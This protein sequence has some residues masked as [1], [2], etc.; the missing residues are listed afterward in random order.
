M[1]TRNR[2]ILIILIVIL[3]MSAVFVSIAM[4]EYKMNYRDRIEQHEEA[5][6]Y[7]VDSEFEKLTRTY[8][9]RLN[10]FTKANKRIVK[11]FKERDREALLKLVNPRFTTFKKE[12]P[13]FHNVNFILPDGRLLLS[14]N[15][16]D[17]FRN[18]MSVY[19][20]IQSI[21]KDT[22]ALHGYII[23][24]DR[25]FFQAVQTVRHNDKNIGFV[26]FRVRTSI[27]NQIIQDVL[28]AEYALG[29]PSNIP[30]RHDDHTHFHPIVI[31]SSCS[32]FDNLPI[33]F[34][35]ESHIQKVNVN[36]TEYI[37]HN[38]EVK[39]FKGDLIGH[40]FTSNDI[41]KLNKRFQ[42]FFMYVL[43]I[44][45]IVIIL[46]ASVLYLGFGAI[47]NK[48]EQMNID[49]ETTI[50][51]RTKELKEANENALDQNKI[52]N[53]LY[54]RFKSMF[55]DHHSV[56]FLVEPRQGRVVDANKAA[57]EFL[58]LDKKQVQKMKISDI[59]LMTEEQVENIL[60]R[61]ISE[62]LKNYISKF[63]IF[64]VTYDIEIQASPIEIDGRKLLFAICYDVTEKVE[65][66]NK[67]KEMNKNLENMATEEAEKRQKQEHLLIQQ[68]KMSSVGEVLSAIIHQWKQPM[69]A[70]S[71]LMQD[72]S[73]S[74]SRGSTDKA[75]LQNISEEA[76]NQI[77]YM[78]QTVEDF[79]RFLM[80]SKSKENFNITNEVVSVIG[81]LYKQ[82]EKDNISVSVTIVNEEKDVVNY[83]AG[84]LLNLE[85]LDI[86]TS[87]FLSHG[88]PS[89]FKQVL[90]NV[91]HNSRDAINEKDESS[92]SG[93]INVV[94]SCIDDYIEIS[95]ADNAGGIPPEI[96]DKVFEPYF[97]TKETSGTGIGLYM[98]KSIIES[99]MD[100][101]ITA[102]NSD[103]GA[104]FTIKLKKSR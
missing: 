74:C 86:D 77:N 22:D 48:V 62:G 19:K 85:N 88:Y 54:K 18:D 57:L 61:S 36:N 41:T 32:I 29:V 58:N 20:Y 79:R 27:M 51:N 92:I 15:E 100:G 33:S 21:K 34:D 104:L 9:S 75:Y 31:D 68:S 76:L 63:K 1:D 82:I 93:K 44:T 42:A 97:T 64:D 90:M 47:L 8:V 23:S 96:L 81:I 10:G 103:L 101:E 80:P 28:D 69:T 50:A 35:Y 11:A 91:I 55:Q 46:S 14:V 25:L 12:N 102:E 43:I 17:K 16:P 30:H 84:K 13:D 52:I 94:V 59:S 3:F 72:I 98:S 37:I 5:L 66:E 78:N 24:N 38:K 26:E 6:G 49:L 83:Q 53:S 73:D 7:I 95:V 89:E 4:Y 60:Q 87:C 40:Y 71:Y 70:I 99:H 65:I 67:L 45:A 56:M 39:N 2:A